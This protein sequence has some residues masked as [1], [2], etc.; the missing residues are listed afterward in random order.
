MPGIMSEGS[1]AG[2]VPRY[3]ARRGSRC[4]HRGAWDRERQF[5]QRSGTGR[6]EQ[7]V[8]HAACSEGIR[9]TSSCGN[10]KTTWK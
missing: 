1:V 4:L 2:S 5:E 10:V 3:G 7:D 9:A 8:Q 6:E